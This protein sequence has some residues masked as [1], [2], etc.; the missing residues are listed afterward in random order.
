MLNL[1]SNV[2]ILS[3]L[4]TIELVPSF[5][6]GSA[7]GLR[8]LLSYILGSFS[9]TALFGILADKFG[10]DAG[11]YLLLFAVAGCIFC[12]YMTHLGVLRLERKKS[13]T[14]NN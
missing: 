7:T 12:C 6:A 1:C 4:Q 13:Q 14:A 9:G 8:G 10:W 2:L 3:S 5:A 11:F